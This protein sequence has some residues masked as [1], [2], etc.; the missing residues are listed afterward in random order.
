MVTYSDSQVTAKAGVNFVRTV[1]ES[2]GSLF[3]KFE[4]ENDL[5]IDAMIEVVLSGKPAGAQIAVQI[6]SGKSY[7]DARAGSC[8][9]PIGSHR[10]YWSRYPLPVFG[11]VYVPSRGT[12]YWTNIKHALAADQE[13]MDLTFSATRANRLDRASFSSIFVPLLTKSEPTLSLSDAIDC[14]GSQVRDEAHLGL[15]VL[16]RRFPNERVT[17]DV[18]V[19]YFRRA[20][21]NDIPAAL[22]YYFAHVPWH[23]DIFGFGEQL[24]AEARDYARALFGAFGEDEVGKLLECIDPDAGIAR[25]TVGQSVEAVVSS[26]P[27]SRA[28][29]RVVTGD[30]E[31]PLVVRESAAI[32]LA[33]HFPDESLPLLEDLL[34]EG[35]WVAGEVARVI[36][37]F[38]SVNLYP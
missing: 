35:S 11:I 12:A 17:W 8:H 13:G 26:L 9:I 24:T 2:A 4:Q 10:E 37:E 6:K 23:G 3:H 18:L 21:P 34:R 38:G 5:G 19:S 33:S 27:R 20:H 29:L 16:F 15:R 22:I 25:G 30:R 31:R 7:F 1:T 14:A 28:L 36:R 32:V